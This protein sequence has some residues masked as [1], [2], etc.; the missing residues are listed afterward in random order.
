MQVRNK[1]LS[2][3]RHLWSMIGIQAG[4]PSHTAGRSLI[5][6]VG[7]FKVEAFTGTPAKSKHNLSTRYCFLRS[8]SMTHSSTCS[9]LI[10]AIATL[11]SSLQF[12]CFCLHHLTSIFSEHNS[13]EP[14]GGP[15]VQQKKTVYSNKAPKAFHIISDTSNTPTRLCVQRNS[16]FSMIV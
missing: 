12:V 16:Q 5:S 14:T 1:R 11:S 9:Q 4:W 15:N 3:A 8:H 7:R 2:V 6:H 10:S 13:L